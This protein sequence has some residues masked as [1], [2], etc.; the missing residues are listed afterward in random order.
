MQQ[1]LKEPNQLLTRIKRQVSVLRS[2]SF[3]F[4]AVIVLLYS[5]RKEDTSWNSDWTAPLVNDTLSLDNLVNDSTLSVNSLSNLEVDLT[6]TILDIGISDIVGIG[7]TVI[8]HSFT[9][10]VPFLSVPPGFS[11]VN[12]IE[13]HTIN[14]EELQLKK[15]RVSSGTIKMRVYNPLSTKAFFTV[16]LPGVS[17]DG[18]EFSENYVAPAGSISSPSTVDAILD[19]SGYE[20]DL[21]GMDGSS[22]NILQ[23]KLLVNSDPAGPTITVTSSHVFKVEAEFKN[24]KIDYARGYFGNKIVADTLTK[25]ID[26]LS[27]LSSGSIDFP[28]A[29]VQFDIVNGMKVDAKATVTLVSSTNFSGNTV[30]LNGT[31]INTPVYLDPATGSWSSLVSSTESILFNGSNSNVETYLENLGKSH[32]IGYKVQLNPWGNTSGGWN[33]IFPNSRLKVRLKAQMPLSIGADGLTLKDTFDLDVEQNDAKTHV[34]SGIFVLKATNAFPFS[35]GATLYLMDSLGN[36]LHTVTGSDVIQS[37]VYGVVDPVDGLKKEDSEIQFVL[38]KAVLTDLNKIKKVA[39]QATFN[40]PDPANG[41]TVQVAIPAGAFLAVKLKAK[42]NI[43]A[44]YN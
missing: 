42:L 9:S 41:N 1:S 22:F 31:N 4:L 3:I 29:T 12:E 18:V 38:T 39:V 8:K 21:T 7:D 32:T 25:Q 30:A 14:V 40:T 17:R 35:C 10:S 20:I 28:S 37:S 44:I 33:E 11:V 36:L 23:S 24:I 6:R 27:N 43:K 15:I 26:F 34:E 2:G 13:E 19:I 16:Q 5:C